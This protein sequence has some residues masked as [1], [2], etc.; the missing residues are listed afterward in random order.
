MHCL[1]FATNPPS[2]F[3]VFLHCFV[4]TCMCVHK[5]TL[6]PLK[7]HIDCFHTGQQS[8]GLL[9]GV[10]R[11]D[12]LTR[13]VET[14]TE[15]IKR[16]KEE[17]FLFKNRFLATAKNITIDTNKDPHHDV[18]TKYSQNL[19]EIVG[20]YKLQLTDGEDQKVVEK[21]LHSSVWSKERARL[22]KTR[23]DPNEISVKAAALAH[24]ALELFRQQICW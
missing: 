9:V 16:K 4:V 8:V 10:G 19:G 22:Q 12:L 6:T 2:Q 1:F 24:K 21:R 3:F 7:A 11:I 18:I 23:A 14:G 17:N 20:K 15:P 5:S 13:R